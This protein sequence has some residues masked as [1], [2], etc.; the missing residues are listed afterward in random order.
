RDW[1]EQQDQPPSDGLRG[2]V[3]L[4]LVTPPTL[5]TLTSFSDASTVTTESL[6]PV[7]V[8]H[9]PA[10]RVAE[11][12][13]RV[14]LGN[15]LAAAGYGPFSVVG[16]HLA[17][18]GT[19]KTEARSIADTVLLMN[20]STSVESQTA[21]G[22][23]SHVYNGTYSY[24]STVAGPA[25]NPSCGAVVFTNNTCQLEARASGQRC[26]ASVLI[27]AL[28]DLIFAN[29]LCWLDGRRATATLDALLLAGS[30]QATSNRFQE[31]AGF[32]VT[33]SGFTVGALN[34]TSQNISTYCLL[35]TG[36]LQPCIDAHN[37]SLVPAQA[38]HDAAKK[39]NLNFTT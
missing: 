35:A 4:I 21:A 9:L 16:N 25:A 37:L 30:I 6:K 1:I 5:E 27:L 19:V 12:S 39:L 28:D 23:Y 13:V 24:A 29:N 26:I 10:L 22:K 14:A 2:G 36:T 3:V 34:I 33:A 11:N 7:Y 18:G 8:P 15:A 20:L 31:A 38:C 32:P 17:T